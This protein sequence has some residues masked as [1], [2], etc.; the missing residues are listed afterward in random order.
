VVLCATGSASRVGRRGDGRTVGGGAGTVQ[1]GN[2]IVAHTAYRNVTGA[3]RDPVATYVFAT[4][5][6]T[7]PEGKRIASV[8]LP[9]NTDLH[10]FTLATG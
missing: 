8:K 3:D 7:A 2:K 1:D 4:I 9:Q 10:V 5:P 6:F